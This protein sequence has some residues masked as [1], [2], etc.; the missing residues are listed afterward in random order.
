SWTPA[1]TGRTWMDI[2]GVWNGTTEVTTAATP[3]GD[4]VTFVLNNTQF[5]GINQNAYDIKPSV[6]LP[7]SFVYIPNTASITTTGTGCTSPIPT[8]TAATQTG[9]KLDFTLSPV[10]YDLYAQCQMTLKYDI[11]V[12]NTGASGT[13]QIFN[14]WQYAATQGGAL[15]V[16]PYADPFNVLVQAG[17]VVLAKTPASQAG[18]LNATANWSVGISNTGLGALFDVSV[19]EYAINPSASLTLTS[20]TSTA[21]T[22]STLTTAPSLAAPKGVIN[23]LAPGKSFNSTVNA[24][25]T[26]C[27]NI[28]NTVY[29]TDRTGATNTSATAHIVLTQKLPNISVTVNPYTLA[30][31]AATPMSVTIKNTGTGVATG[32]KLKTNL[33]AQGMTVSAVGAGWTYNTT[34]GVFTYGAGTVAAGANLTLNF[35]VAA[36][37]MCTLKSAANIS[38]TATYSNECAEAYNTPSVSSV[39]NAPA[40][41]PSL[42]L[43]N[44]SYATGTVTPVVDRFAVGTSARFLVGFSVKN[45]NLINGTQFVIHNTLPAGTGTSAITGIT[46]TAPAGTTA[47]CAGASAPACL[48]GDVVTL[49][50]TKNKLPVADLII[51]YT[52][53]SN[54]CLGGTTLNNAATVTA[55]ST[56]T[57]AQTCTLS[58]SATSKPLLVNNPAAAVTQSFNVVNTP[59]A[60]ASF[61]T[62]SPDVT[63]FNTRA[64]TGEGEFIAFNASYNFGVGVGTWTGST[65]Q[66]DFAGS[67]A[68]LVPNTLKYSLNAAAAVVVPAARVTCG[69]GSIATN[70]CSRNMSIDLG[71]ITANAGNVANQS[72]TFTY[73]TTI[74]DAALGAVSTKKL[75]QLVTMTV[76]GGAGG[77]GACAAG[78]TQVYKQGAFVPVAKAEAKIALSMPATIDV[79]ESATATMT[80]SNASEESASHVMASFPTNGNYNFITNPTPTFGGLFTTTN[81]TYTA[82]VPAAPSLGGPT[83]VLTPKLSA[84]GTITFVL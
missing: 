2:G 51:D 56:A 60:G 31:N 12:D 69:S 19:D 37:N 28:D 8:I 33:P 40:A 79:C 72:L 38:W 22:G 77:I 74:P 64:T 25:I 80:V 44:D 17:A 42:T 71:F 27:K 15:N 34:T 39:L 14:Q 70:N 62:G 16:N 30:Y 54:T 32:F 1:Q 10:G 65:F 82:A 78:T 84:N 23:Y 20:M 24:T 45:A 36:T 41:V 66:D 57:T 76:A 48:A 52:A 6:L 83:F 5:A 47:T 58:A 3:S 4:H 55:T 67:G 46:L 68:T 49:T 7:T 9:G 81:I 73:Q 59:I 21:P 29:S 11:K 61:E 53:P 63:P 75:T 13:S 43:S 18:T 50:I 26:S 35:S